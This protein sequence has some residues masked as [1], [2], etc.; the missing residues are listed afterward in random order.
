[1]LNHSRVLRI[2]GLAVAFIPVWGQAPPSV[3]SGSKPAL[4]LP[5][6]YGSGGLVLA[7]SR[8]LDGTPL[9][10][11]HTGHF[12]SAF[13]QS[14]SPLNTAIATE[15]TLLPIPSPASGFIY[16]EDPTTGLVSRSTQ[17]FGPILAER[18]ETIGKK[19]FYF[20]VAYQHF[21]FSTLDGQKLS[22]FPA[23]FTHDVDPNN[24]RS[25]DVITSN[26]SIDLTVNQTVLLMTAGITNGLDVSVALPIVNTSMSATSNA[27]IHRIATAAKPF[28]HTF[29][30]GTDVPQ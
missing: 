25:K 13:Q 17:S 7:P 24:V 3:Q 27:N 4:V 16:H 30:E 18:A 20:G 12:N 19:K 21:S 26:N 9:I 2:L 8:N 6:L 15:L 5:N 29:V 22:S 28:T 23:L 14:F 10:P 1:M 11:S